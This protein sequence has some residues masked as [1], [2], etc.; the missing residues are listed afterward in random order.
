MAISFSFSIDD[1]AP[2]VALQRIGESLSDMTELMD[3][4]GRALVNAAVERIIS[5]NVAPDGDTWT[6][7]RRVKEKGGKTLHRS[8]L[9]A[10][11][12]AHTASADHVEVG[13]NVVY[14]RVMHQGAAQGEFGA[15]MGRTRPSDKRPW[16][17]DYF[18]HLPWGDIPARPYLGVSEADRLMIEDLVD[19]H[20]GSL[21]DGLQ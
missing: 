1:H 10:S 11:S 14:A 6:P 16:S 20:F 7:S 13:T 12:I 2:R 18:A 21:V 5:T 15:A 9:L 17:Q 8:G 4:I 19:V 3:G